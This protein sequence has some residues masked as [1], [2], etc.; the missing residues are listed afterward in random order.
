MGVTLALPLL[1]SMI[2]AGTATGAHGGAPEEPLLRHL[3]PAWRDDGQVDAG[4]GRQRLRLHRVVETARES[5]R[6]PERRHQPRASDGRR[7]GL[8][9][10]RGSRAFSSGVPERRASGEGHRCIAARR[11]ISCSRITSGRTRLFPRSKCASKKSRSTAA[12]ATAA[13]TTTPS[14]GGTTRYRCRW[15]TVRRSSSS[16]CLV[17]AATPRCVC[18]ASSRTRA[19]STR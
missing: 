8:R 19:S 17:M 16:A 9:R 10:R 3:H 4:E 18:R 14:R 2:P 5:S 6:S 13:R 11:S 12:P 7:Q 15:R 1:D